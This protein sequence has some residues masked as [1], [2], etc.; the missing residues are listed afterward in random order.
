MRATRFGS[1]SGAYLHHGIRQTNQA[2]ERVTKHW[3]K[4]RGVRPDDSLKSV[5]SDRRL[6]AMKLNKSGRLRS[7]SARRP[8]RCPGLGHHRGAVP[9]PAGDARL[10]AVRNER[11]SFTALFRTLRVKRGHQ[12]VPV[13]AQSRTIQPKLECVLQRL[14]VSDIRRLTPKDRLAVVDAHEAALESRGGRAERARLPVQRPV[15]GEDRASAARSLSFAPPNEEQFYFV[16]SSVRKS[17]W[18]FVRQLRGPHLST[19]A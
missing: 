19:W 15:A 4:W 13:P 17:V 11:R 6:K 12:R 16:P 7:R 1:Q 3:G 9:Q 2:N 10:P 8:T 5:E 18:T 14:A